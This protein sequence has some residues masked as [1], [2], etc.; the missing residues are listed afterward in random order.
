M[1]LSTIA[2][3]HDAINR[4]ATPFEL[5]DYFPFNLNGLALAKGIG[6]RLSM[7][8]PK[9]LDPTQMFGWCN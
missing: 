6:I 9:P 1:N 3:R 4:N 7:T 2:K 5:A 8:Q